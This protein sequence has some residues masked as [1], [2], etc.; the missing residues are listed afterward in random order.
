[1]R[2]PLGVASPPPA[3]LRPATAPRFQP[4]SFFFLAS[5]PGKITAA[6]SL[7]SQSVP[8]GCSRRI[9]DTVVRLPQQATEMRAGWAKSLPPRDCSRVAGQDLGIGDSSRPPAARPTMERAPDP[10]SAREGG[11]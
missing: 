3:S 2:N 6:A 7:F 4:A 1:M 10:P 8:S 11:K 5:L 9:T